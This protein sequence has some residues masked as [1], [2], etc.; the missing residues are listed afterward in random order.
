MSQGNAQLMVIACCIFA[1]CLTV[2][3][4]LLFVSLWPYREYVG[5]SLLGVLLLL[6]VV[7]AKG[8]LNEQSLRHNAFATMRKH[9]LI[10]RGS[11]CFGSKAY[12]QTL[13]ASH[14]NSRNIIKSI[15]NGSVSP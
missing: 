2:V 13:T 4:T 5:A 9:H 3:Y 14:H 15:V 11:R 10:V 12:S 8:R 6:A 1:V 7:Y